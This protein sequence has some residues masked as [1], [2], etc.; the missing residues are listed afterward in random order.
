MIKPDVRGVNS[1]S[2]LKEYIPEVTLSFTSTNVLVNP[3]VM[4]TR[5]F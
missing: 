1:V 5:E 2:E 3:A 4:E